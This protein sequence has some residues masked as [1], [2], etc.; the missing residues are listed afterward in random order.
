M[1]KKFWALP[2]L[3]KNIIVTPPPPPPPPPPSPFSPFFFGG[4]GR[5]GGRGRGGRGRGGNHCTAPPKG[6]GRSPPPFSLRIL[7]KLFYAGPAHLEHFHFFSQSLFFKICVIY[8]RGRSSVHSSKLQ[9]LM[10]S[11][12]QKTKFIVAY[13]NE[14]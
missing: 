9:K 7:Q 14:I 4:G 10:V 5:G 8:P 1:S 12:Q 6:G 3:L 2:A 11:S 13:F